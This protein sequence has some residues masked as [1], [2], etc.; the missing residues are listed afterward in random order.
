MH[1]CPNAHDRIVEG[2]V[3]VEG[4]GDGR[5]RQRPRSSDEHGGVDRTRLSGGEV[6]QLPYD[7]AVPLERAVVCDR[8]DPTA[9]GRSLVQADSIRDPLSNVAHSD[10]D[11][12]PLADE[13]PRGHLL[14]DRQVSRAFR[15]AGFKVK[16]WRRRN[17][18]AA[19]WWRERGLR[20]DAVIRDRAHDFVGLAPQIHRDG[21]AACAVC[22]LL[23]VGLVDAGGADIGGGSECAGS[24]RLY[25]SLS[26]CRDR[27]GQYCDGGACHHS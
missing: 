17:M 19:R 22:D 1:G 27:S 11:R 21:A 6:P 2:R 3:S 13:R 8:D 24:V 7:D 14:A 18:G 5:V 9:V 23:S 16:T 15:I 12:H 10:R 4:I 26:E 25:V 20:S